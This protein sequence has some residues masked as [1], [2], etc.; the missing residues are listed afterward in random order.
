MRSDILNENSGRSDFNAKVENVTPAADGT[1]S[2]FTRSLSTDDSGKVFFCDIS[3]YD[4]TFQLPAVADSVGVHYKWILNNA[5]N[6]EATKN[7][8]VCTN[9]AGEDIVGNVML[10]GAVLEITGNSSVEVDTSAGAATYGDWLSVISD[11]EYWYIDGSVVT[12]SAVIQAAG[13]AMTS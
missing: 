11:G 2:S 9:A 12:A 3:T 7:L 10:A 1:A 13:I 6:N 5:S 4:A 8:L